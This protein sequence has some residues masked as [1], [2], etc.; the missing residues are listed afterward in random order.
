[1]TAEFAVVLPAMVA[2]TLFGIAAIGAQ[3][4]ELKLQQVAATAARALTRQESPADVQA[5][6]QTT[7]PG[8]EWNSTVVDEVLCIELRQRL[9]RVLASQKVRVRSCAWVGASAH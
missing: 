4:Q 8:A 1:M 3:A 9:S 5:W 7:V 2:V 6:V